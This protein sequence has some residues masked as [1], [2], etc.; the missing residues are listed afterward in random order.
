MSTREALYRKIREELR[1]ES[2]LK[3]RVIAKR[4]S[5]KRCDVNSILYCMEYRDHFQKD[6]FYKWYLADEEAVQVTSR[7]EARKAPATCKKC[8]LYKNDTCF[9]AKKI[10]SFFKNS[11]DISEYELNLWPKEMSGP[12]G[13]LYC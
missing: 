10:C 5:V 1:K 11:P 3:A 7:R 12:Y 8:M 9:G 4:L 13:T 6:E 2:G